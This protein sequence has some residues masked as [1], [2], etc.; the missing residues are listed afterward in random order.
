MN[1]T[2]V[3]LDPIV[4]EFETLSDAEAYDVWFRQKVKQSLESTKPNLPHDQA[5]A[6]IDAELARRK[7][8]R[9]HR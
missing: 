6:T 5:L 8:A 2:A 1:N 3:K 9:A 4:Y 7:A